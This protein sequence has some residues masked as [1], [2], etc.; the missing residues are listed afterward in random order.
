MPFPSESRM[1]RDIGRARIR[2]PSML[3]PPNTA[4]FSVLVPLHGRT[5]PDV[6][7]WAHHPRQHGDDP[8]KQLL[9]PLAVGLRDDPTPDQDVQDRPAFPCR[10]AG[11]LE[12]PATFRG[13][14]LTVPLSD[15]QR[16]GLRGAHQLVPRTT[17]HRLSR[18][19]SS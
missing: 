7:R 10:S 13:R 17:V 11:N 12:K 6:I 3:L 19:A 15:V 5:L 9:S 2:H 18:F 1:R 16:E 4:V 8:N 14:K